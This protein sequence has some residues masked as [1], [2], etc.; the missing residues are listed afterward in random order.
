MFSVQSW[1]CLVHKELGVLVHLALHMLLAVLALLNPKL[2][3]SVL[4]GELI[5]ILTS[6]VAVVLVADAPA[7]LGMGTPLQKYEQ[8]LLQVHS[9][10]LSL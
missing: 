3:H 7:G 9:S 4:L 5:S 8:Y 2:V 10:R 6:L 1:A